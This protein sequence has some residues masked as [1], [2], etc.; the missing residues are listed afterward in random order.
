[1][2]LVHQE[3]TDKNY[4]NRAQLPNDVELLKD[5]IE[6]LLYKV[7]R[8]EEEI[9][10]LKRHRF[11][12]R[13]EKKK[14]SSSA[15]KAGASSATKGLSPKASYQPANKNHP[16]RKPL[17]KHLARETIEHDVESTDKQ[18]LCCQGSLT[19]I[20]DLITEQLDIKLMHL[21]VKEHR[22]A[23]YV[24]RHCYSAVT[25]AD[26][27][28]QPI[29]KGIASPQLLAHLI[30]EKFGY[31]MPLYRLERWFK[32]QE[33]EVTRTTMSEWFYPF[34]LLF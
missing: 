34:L 22:R 5:I 11:G 3:N 30:V 32:D 31:Y 18:C 1:M 13:S 28:A 24:C 27:P 10:A 14:G 12:Q 4:S 16:G 15:T 2:I 21:I 26:L 6:Q 7:T 33:V 9:A 8:L 20:N 17:P 25:V 23:K 19:R 29:D